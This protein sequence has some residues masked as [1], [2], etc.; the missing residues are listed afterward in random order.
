MK[1]H[2]HLDH[3]ERWWASLPTDHR[4]ALYSAQALAA[5]TGIPTRNLP[6]VA[7]LAGWHR[8]SRW[9]IGLDGRR[10]Q[11]TFYA[12]P[13][14]RVPES[15]PRGRPRRSVYTLTDTR[16]PSPFDDAYYAPIPSRR[17]RLA[18]VR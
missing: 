3:L 12:P 16:P 11:R 10:K 7:P 5:A 1:L 9:L 17:A 4:Q 8:A 2:D 18:L 14:H 15:A 13:G 6:L